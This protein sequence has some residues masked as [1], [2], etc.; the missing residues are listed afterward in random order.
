MLD[1]NVDTYYV[2]DFLKILDAFYQF[3]E[4]SLYYDFD[5]NV[6]HEAILDF[7]AC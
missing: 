6:Q 7:I 2:F 3:K 1:E 4:V 5:N